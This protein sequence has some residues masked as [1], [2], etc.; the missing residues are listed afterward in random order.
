MPRGFRFTS[1]AL[2]G[3][4]L[5]FTVPGEVKYKISVGSKTKACAQLD[6]V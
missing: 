6:W 2:G 4:E 1:S 5:L 3:S